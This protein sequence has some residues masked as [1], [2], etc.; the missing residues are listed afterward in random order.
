MAWV[1][2][3]RKRALAFGAIIVVCGALVLGAVF[4]LSGIYNVAASAR[5]FYITDRLIKLT[6]WRSI[7][8]HSA[9]VDVPPLDDPELVRLGAR[10]FAT[11]CAPCHSAPGLEQNP[12]I[13]GMYP[14]APPL[15]EAVP[16]WETDELYWIVRHGLKFTGMP[17]WPGDGRTE[18]PWPVVAF[19][20][21]LPGMTP[22]EYAKISGMPEGGLSFGE[23]E[24]QGFANCVGCHGD[25]TQPPVSSL[26]PSLNGQ[27]DD[28]L[29]RALREYADN[30]RQSGFMEP[31]AVELSRD[32]IERLAEAF[33]AMEPAPEEAPERVVPD[34]L[35]AHGRSIATQGIPDRKVAA[36]LSCHSG[37]SSSQFPRIEGLSQDYLEMQLELFRSGVRGESA[38]GAIMAKVAERL[39]DRDIAAVAAWFST[40]ERG[41]GQDVSASA[42]EGQR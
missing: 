25:E 5:H 27:K 18:E 11:G 26:V 9:S 17:Q 28:Y 38:Y 23:H 31:L 24:D 8:T 37:R 33:A 36:C 20:L 35:L 3:P 41:D 4:I 40:R 42:G 29:V 19:L 6:L 30:L 22:E 15:Q 2:L 34:E 16:G 32:E 13:S 14:T 12:I 39:E 1:A 7:D 21:E 10:H